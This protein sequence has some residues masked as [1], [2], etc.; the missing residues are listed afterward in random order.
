MDI[1]KI[2]SQLNAD[3]EYRI[4][5]NGRYKNVRVYI[6]LEEETCLIIDTSKKEITMYHNYKKDV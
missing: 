6:V 5:G 2:I 3:I 1:E 4:D